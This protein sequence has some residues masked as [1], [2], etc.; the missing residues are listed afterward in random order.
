MKSD[1]IKM[2]VAVAI[3]AIAAIVFA[4]NMGL[5]SGGGS[6]STPTVNPGPSGES[7]RRGGAQQ[8]PGSK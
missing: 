1:K 3:L 4:W 8:A 7:G 2:I 6:S 5:F